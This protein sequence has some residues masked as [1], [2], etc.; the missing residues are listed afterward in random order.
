[1]NIYQKLNRGIVTEASW[2]SYVIFKKI[3]AKKYCKSKKY[4]MIVIDNFIKLFSQLFERQIELQPWEITNNLPAIVAEM[5]TLL[6]EDYKIEKG[7]AIHETAT[8]EQGA[9]LKAPVIIGGHCF[10]GAN[11]YLRGG[12]YLDSGVKIGT[13]CE[14]KSSLIF[15]NS[16]IAHFNFIGDSIIG[17]HVNFEAGS[18]TT[19]HYNERADKNIPVVYNA[20]I[21]Q[22]GVAKF[23]SLVGD[24]SK[25]GANAVLSPG[26]ILLPN[27]IV[28]RLVLIDQVN[29]LYGSGS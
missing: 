1:V 20:K 17:S 21:I 22:T 29:D 24:H 5:I 18:I 13:G 11:A 14:I 7:I 23:G 4:K 3:L 2:I 15:N 27:S 19:N 28:N 6:N 8:V 16:A 26:T 10:I 25:I 9:V 12:V